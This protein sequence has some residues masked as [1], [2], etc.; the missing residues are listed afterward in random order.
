MKSVTFDRAA[1]N[2]DDMHGFSTETAAAIARL[3]IEAGGIHAGSRI[4]EPGIGTGRVALPLAHQSG[5]SVIGID[6]SNPMMQKLRNK[7]DNETVFAICADAMQLPLPD[8]AFD[9]AVVTHVFHLVADWQVA[10]A[11]IGRVLRPDGLLLNS[12]TW[13]S[14]NDFIRVWRDVLGRKKTS[15][16]FAAFGGTDF[17]DEAGWE[18]RGDTLELPYTIT[19]TPGDYISGVENRVQSATWKMTEDE[20]AD[21]IQELHE[22][23]A[24]YDLPLDKPFEREAIFHVAPYAPHK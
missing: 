15:D 12:W 5:A 13:Y 4:V 16:R 14:E 17:L 7:Q 2:Y 9:T 20:I 8:N 3:F 22:A 23:A 1:P 6:L 24:Q 21:G 19:R 11:E 10:L 18:R